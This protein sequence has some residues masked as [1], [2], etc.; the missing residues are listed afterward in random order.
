MQQN[1]QQDKLEDANFTYEN[2]IFKFHPKNMQIGHFG[3]KSKDFYFAPNNAIRQIR[4]VDFK[5]DNG[6]FEFQSENTHIKQF[7]S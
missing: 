6:F 2:S 4:G 1:L 5:Y 7:L 3:P